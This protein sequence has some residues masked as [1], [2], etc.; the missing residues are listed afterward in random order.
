MDVTK[1]ISIISALFTLSVASERLVEIIKGFFPQL[2][3]QNLE[4]QAEAL[5]KAKISIL[6]VVCGIVTSFL[7]SPLLAGIFRDLFKDSA[8]PLFISWFGSMGSDV[9]C[10]FNLNANG[11]LLI[12]ALGLLASGGSSLWNSVLEYL[13]KIKDLKRAEVRRTEALR[14]IEVARAEVALNAARLRLS[15]SE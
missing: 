6:A 15:K 9:P 3:E 12:L 7:A 11:F 4:G 2:N 14:R 8:C 10:G 13:L 5:R 1:L